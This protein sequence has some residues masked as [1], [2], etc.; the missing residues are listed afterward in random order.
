M[1][2]CVCERERVCVYVCACVSGTYAPY[3][4]DSTTE[5]EFVCVHVCHVRMLGIVL[6][7]LLNVT[8]LQK[9]SISTCNTSN[10]ICFQIIILNLN[11][12]YWYLA[13]FSLL[14]Y[15]RMFFL[16]LLVAQ[17]KSVNVCVMTSIIQK[18]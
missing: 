3:C 5:R 18:D 8:S 15:W 7:P 4:I 1:C 13:V 12:L 16:H 9:Q 10:K 6:I 14:R 17:G 2:V 11:V